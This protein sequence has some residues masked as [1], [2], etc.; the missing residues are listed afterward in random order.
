MNDDRLKAIEDKQAEILA[1]LDLLFGHLQQHGKNLDSMTSEM[2][3]NYVAIDGMFQ[4][5]LASLKA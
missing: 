5:I 2:K 1:K 3:S 4:E